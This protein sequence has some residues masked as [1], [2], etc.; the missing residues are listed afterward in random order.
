MGPAEPR[1]SKARHRWRI[2]P[3][4]SFISEQTI[5]HGS[6]GTNPKA[7]EGEQSHPPGH[8]V[9]APRTAQHPGMVSITLSTHKT[10][11]KQSV[12]ARSLAQ[13]TPHP[14]PFAQLRCRPQLCHPWP[15]STAL[16]LAGKLLLLSWGSQHEA[17]ASSHGQAIH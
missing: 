9:E 12:P 4:K 15:K 16:T 13:E 5:I 11:L 8:S 17:E 6:Y 10:C 14:L 2:H 1:L 3:N 7:D